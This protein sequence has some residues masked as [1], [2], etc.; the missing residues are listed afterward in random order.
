MKII[1]FNPKVTIHAKIIPN[2]ILQIAA[3][4]HGQHDYVIVDGN[5]E[6]DPLEKIMDLFRDPSFGFFC[7]TV[8]PGPQLAQAIPISKMIREQYPHVTIIWGGYFASN[9]SHTVIRSGYVD[10]VINGPGDHA[11]PELLQ[12]LTAR[13]SVA[14]ISNLVYRTGDTIYKTPKA[15]LIDQDT[16]PDLPYDT[17]H[18]FYPMD[19]YLGKTFLGTRTIAYHSSIGCPFSCSFCGVVPIF[20]TRWKGKSAE[21]IYRD[22]RF[23]KETYGGNAITFH[24]NNFFVSEKRV[25][26]FAERIMHDG[27]AWWGEGR[28]DTMDKYSDASLATLRRSGCRMI[29]FGAESG[30]DT[31]LRQMDKGGTQSGNKLR[32][33]AARLR[34]HDIIPEYSFVLGFPAATEDE[35]WKLIDQEIRFIREIKSINPSTEII[36]YIYTPVPTEGSDLY[37]QALARGFQFP[38]HLDE[39]MKP[40]WLNFDLHRQYVTPWL[41]PAMIRHIHDFETVL[42]AQYPTISDLKLT[43]F[44][45]TAMRWFSSWRYRFHRYAHPYELKFL[46]KY[47]LRYRRPEKEG[48]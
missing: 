46:Q 7:C 1:F 9:Q 19:G 35:V 28:I 4:I 11:F 18:S 8:M 32:S 25:V 13:T 38:R 37:N 40:E 21:R 43:A 6:S 48:F 41:T 12:A 45:R 26:E 14:T 39:W 16:L 24:D 15:D 47:W 17:L 10:Y 44:Q 33:F 2:S 23:L 34:E 20:E 29:F 42:N 27:M 22:I 36:I 31:L 3:S 5:R 30:N